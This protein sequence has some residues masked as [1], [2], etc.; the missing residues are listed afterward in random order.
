MRVTCGVIQV[1][2]D[3]VNGMEAQGLWSTLTAGSSYG[4]VDGRCHSPPAEWS[5][6]N[7]GDP[8]VGWTERRNCSGVWPVQVLA[9]Q[10]RCAHA[11]GG[12]DDLLPW[13]ELIETPQEITAHKKF[14]DCDV[15]APDEEDVELQTEF[16]ATHLL[17]FMVI[18]WCYL[19]M[20]QVALTPCRLQEDDNF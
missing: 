7:F 11:A 3:G 2:D 9:K 17:T 1:A 8:H 6:A 5:Q 13:T 14:V 4:D 20:V 19:L 18:S 15:L 12:G 16:C 10:D